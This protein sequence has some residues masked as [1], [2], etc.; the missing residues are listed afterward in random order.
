MMSVLSKQDVIDLKDCELEEFYIEE[1]KGSV[2]I[3]TMTVEERLAFDEKHCSSDGT[4]KNLKDPELVYDM[5]SLCLKNSDGSSMF[6]KEDCKLLKKKN[7]KVIH[8]IFYKALSMNYLSQ[9]VVENIK[10]K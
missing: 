2:N 10:K 9:E 7:A 5:I 3:G 4:F 8:K 1:W 6:S